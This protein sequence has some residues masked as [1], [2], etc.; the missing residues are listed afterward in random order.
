MREQLEQYVN[1]LFAGSAENEDMKQEILQNT[2]DR[3]DDM[4]T[5]GKAPEAAYRLAISGIGD[6]SEL[7][8]NDCVPPSPVAPV[9]D[10]V[11]AEQKKKMRAVAVGMYICSVLPLLVLGNLGNGILGLVMMFLLIAA[12]TVLIIM[13]SDEDEQKDEK[14][15]EETIPPARR[16]THKALNTASLALF[17]V[18]SFATGAW[19]I[20]WLIWPIMAAVKGIINAVWDLKEGK[21]DA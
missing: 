3:Y 14:P 2:L 12:A 16:A 15:A 21:H 7:M 19:H 18:L 1:L 8:G 13:G 6:I 20:T 17:L 9:K 5:E 11:K 10:P 4:I